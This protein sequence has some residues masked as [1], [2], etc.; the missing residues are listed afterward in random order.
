MKK[1]VAL[2]LAV[3]TALTLFTAA[4]AQTLC[5]GWPPSEDPAVTEELKALFDKGTET[6]TGVS[7]LPV[8]YL[9]SQVVAGTNHAFLCKAVTAYPGAL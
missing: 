5:G 8:A 4:S 7:Y 3:L 1:I 2:L 9:G 6:L